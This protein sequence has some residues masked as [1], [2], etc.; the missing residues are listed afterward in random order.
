MDITSDYGSLVRG[1]SP[2]GRATLNPQKFKV[3]RIFRSCV[4]AKFRCSLLRAF[5]PELRLRSVFPKK[6]SFPRNP[7]RE[8]HFFEFREKLI[9]V[10]FENF[11]GNFAGF[12]GGFF[13]EVDQF[14]VENER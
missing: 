14:D 4:F 9:F 8:R 6:K 10:F 1:S 7:S 2:R 11:V 13:R 3:L 5:V 12:F